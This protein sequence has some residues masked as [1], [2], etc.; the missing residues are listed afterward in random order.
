MT[1][2]AMTNE[3]LKWSPLNRDQDPALRGVSGELLWSRQ[4]AEK[5][6][7]AGRNL[8]LASLGAAGS[9]GELGREAVTRLVE[10]GRDLEK[11]GRPAIEKRVR[12]GGEK[13]RDL[14]RESGERIRG[15]GRRAEHRFEERMEDALQRFGVPSR[16]EVRGL[17]DRIEKLTRK[18]E[19]MTARS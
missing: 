19:N 10:R 12:E 17:I 7:L 13:L 11:S 4:R 3:D 5:L 9:L 16:N 2:E 18:V 8:W 14:G 1:A 15:F 6:R